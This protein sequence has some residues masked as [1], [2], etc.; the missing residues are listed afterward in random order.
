MDISMPMLSIGFSG[1]E[2]ARKA[3]I[4]IE[5]YQALW[6]DATPNLV[7]I[8]PNDEEK[9]I[10]DTVV[11]DT[12]LVWLVGAVDT[13]YEG[14]GQAQ[15]IFGDSEKHIIGKSEVFTVNVR[16]SL[17]GDTDIVVPE[18]MEPWMNR[19]L[20]AAD[21]VVSAATDVSEDAEAA[22][23]AKEEAEAAA[24]SAG[25]SARGAS[26]SAQSAGKASE[27]AGQSAETAS[28]ASKQ[29]VAAKE[30]IESLGVTG[31]TL[32]P[33]E[34]VTVEKTVAEGIVTLHFAIPRGASGV[35]AII[36]D[37]TWWNWDVATE[38]F[39]DSDIPSSGVELVRLL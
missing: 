18:P 30:A 22:T 27:N 15:I 36:K 16:N 28:S 1:E 6:P 21:T 25:E 7:V 29:A 38:Q 26:V 20:E 14:Q 8:R 9:Y 32:G 23:R 3:Y 12:N 33:E 35:S 19:L 13:I 11:E 37:G 2:N 4:P 5:R 39:I 17:P 34:D 10:A 31:E 24:R